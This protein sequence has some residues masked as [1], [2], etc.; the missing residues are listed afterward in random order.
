MTPNPPTPQVP[1]DAIPTTNPSQKDHEPPARRALLRTIILVIVLAGALTAFYFSPIRP[2][3]QDTAAVRRTL[4]HLGPWTYPVCILSVAVLV[5][6]GAPRL[7]FAALGAMVLGFWWGLALTQ[8]GALIGYYAVFLFVRW[9]G[10][11]WVMHRWPKLRRW[12][13][14]LKDQGIL[15]VIL[16][17]QI[18]VHGTLTNLCLGLS[19]IKHHQFLIGSAIGLLP[20]AIPIALLSAG[21]VRGSFK[22]A[23]PY[24]AAAA[25]AF[26]FIGIVCVRAVRAMRNTPSGAALI[27]EVTSTSTNG[28]SR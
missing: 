10:R 20:E 6:C 25:I 5:A 26:A 18:P 7:L 16:I 21:L 17:R 22:D 11:D 4:A 15:G 24:L 19:G 3:L 1:A 27:N 12:A 23:I 8:A 13:G 9:G 14:L 28:A 2:W